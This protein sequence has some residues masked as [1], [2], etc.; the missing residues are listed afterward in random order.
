[1]VIGKDEFFACRTICDYCAERA[2]RDFVVTDAYAAGDF[3]AIAI[4]GAI[5]GTY[6]TNLNDIGFYAIDLFGD[7]FGGTERGRWEFALH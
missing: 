3:G 6:I 4:T 5:I 7:S 1:M 2:C